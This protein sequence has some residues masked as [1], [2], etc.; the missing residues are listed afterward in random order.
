MITDIL[1]DF[2]GILETVRFE[3]FYTGFL[4]IPKEGLRDFRRFESSLRH[5]LD[6][7]AI[8]VGEYL[9]AIR[10]VSSFPGSDADYIR[11]IRSY[12]DF[13]NQLFEHLRTVKDRLRLSIFSNNS[14]IF[15][16]DNRRRE[17]GPVFDRQ[18]Y[19]FEYGISKPD[20]RFYREVL[21]LLAVQPDSCLFIDDKEVNL[22][23][24]RKLGMKTR[25]Y[26]GRDDLE[27]TLC[28]PSRI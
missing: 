18:F 9:A 2:G 4:R 14:E 27:K 3:E 26:S 12:A 15:I 19:S 24:A 7:R 5:N 22:V 8:S 17:L 25:L 1:L 10:N 16:D 20:T 6:R 23:P 11:S 13:D 28:E 21:E